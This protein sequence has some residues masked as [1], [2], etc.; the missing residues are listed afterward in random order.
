MI[1]HV[2]RCILLWLSIRKSTANCTFP[3]TGKDLLPVVENKLAVPSI[4]MPQDLTTGNPLHTTLKRKNY[5]VKCCH[6]MSIS[7]IL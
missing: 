6:M 1:R 3:L 2:Q 7:V 4:G 5:G